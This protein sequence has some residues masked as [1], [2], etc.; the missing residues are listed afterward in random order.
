MK[1]LFILGPNLN[2]VGIRDRATYGTETAESI[3]AD[4]QRFA[5]ELGVELEIYQSNHEG[6]IIDKIHAA[7][8]N[9][10]GIMRL[11]ITATLLLTLFPR[12]ISRPLK[13]ICPISGHVRNSAENP[14]FR[15]YVSALLQASAKRAIFWG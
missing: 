12:C 3:N 10:D 9:T 13:H 4:V 14:L 7:Y 1:I 11:R 2:M 5:D 15:R 8:G 6:N